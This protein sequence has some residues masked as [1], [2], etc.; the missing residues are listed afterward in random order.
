M[1]D[2][3]KMCARCGHEH[4][5]GVLSYSDDNVKL[6]GARP[7]EA[8]KENAVGMQYP[9]ACDDFAQA[10]EGDRIGLPMAAVAPEELKALW[11]DTSFLNAQ[12]PMAT[13]IAVRQILSLEEGPERNKEFMGLMLSQV[14]DIRGALTKDE[15]KFAHLVSHTD[16]I[17]EGMKGA[18][19]LAER[20]TV[21]NLSIDDTNERI[22][23][24]ATMLNAIAEKLGVG[25][26]EPE[27]TDRHIFTQANSKMQDEA[28]VVDGVPTDD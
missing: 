10:Q 27:Q 7:C 25:V 22:D 24:L 8:P 23:R 4:A 20:L 26:E 2:V 6:Y 12:A 21:V 9:C 15:S 1:K 5:W 19:Q 28:V 14:T 13:R 3:Q 17:L 16:E 11:A 18:V